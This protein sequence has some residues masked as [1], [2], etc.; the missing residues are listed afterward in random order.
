MS[1]D[2]VRQG[3]TAVF[4]APPDSGAA[5]ANASAKV[6][7][8][9]IQRALRESADAGIDEVAVIDLQGFDPNELNADTFYLA[10]T[11]ADEIRAYPAEPATGA[12]GKP[13][14]FLAGFGRGAPDG[15]AV[16]C[17]GFLWNCRYGGGCV[18][19]IAPDGSIDRLVEMPCDNVTTCTFGGE[20]LATLFVTTARGG[21]ERS[22]RLAGSV[23]AYPAPVPGL[24]ERVFRP[25]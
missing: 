13:R 17:E 5:N 21:T 6:S 1:K 15:S 11:L 2:I 22:Q 16:D 20:G 7:L 19:R 25:A 9:N 23:F 24:P 4:Y 18:V 8:R 10:D 3:L 12:L 14:A